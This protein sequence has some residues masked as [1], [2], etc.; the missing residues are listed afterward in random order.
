MKMKVKASFTD[1]SSICV[2][3][4][5]D[6]QSCT[7]VSI[8]IQT[9]AKQNTDNFILNSNQQVIR[10]EIAIKPIKN[11]GIHTTVVRRGYKMQ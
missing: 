11:F 4:V 8:M 6:V 2:W 5:R 1:S 3:V 7:F 9:L 10:I